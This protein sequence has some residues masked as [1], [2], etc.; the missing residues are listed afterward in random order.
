MA[1]AAKQ[2]DRIGSYEVL[3][4]RPGPHGTHLYRVKKVGTTNEQT[5]LEARAPG[6]DRVRV[7]EELKKLRRHVRT[8]HV[9]AIAEAFDAPD[10]NAVCLI[11]ERLGDKTLHDWMGTGPGSLEMDR[12]VPILIALFDALGGAHGAVDETRRLVPIV[13]GDLRPEAIAMV[14]SGR[15]LIVKVVGLGLEQIL[16]TVPPPAVAY[17]APEVQRGDRPTPASDVYSAG[18][19]AWQLLAGRHPFSNAEGVLPPDAT[20]AAR[21]KTGELPPLPEAIAAAVPPSLADLL[22]E[23][24]TLDPALRPTAQ[25]VRVR[26]THALNP[27]AWAKA[28]LARVRRPQTSRGWIGAVL[29]VLVLLGG[30]AISYGYLRTGRLE[31]PQLPDLAQLPWGIGDEPA[32]RPH[33]LHRPEPAAPRPP[34]VPDAA[35]APAPAPVNP[36]V[37]LVGGITRMVGVGDRRLIAAAL[38][39]RLPA[40]QTCYERR[41]EEV[42]TL[43]GEVAVQ[44]IVTPAGPF[45]SVDVGRNTTGDQ[46]L[47]LCVQ[48]QLSGVR[49]LPAPGTEAEAWATFSF[50]I[51]GD[52]DA[53]P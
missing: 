14:A 33:K 44:F 50:T 9:P 4:G 7:L 38:R 42:P 6:A 52:A 10:R 30:G 39:R 22:V 40:L 1:N 5:L 47:G 12:L 24:C 8:P 37:Q 49:V 51:G 2:G 28:R 29:V 53:G 16:P 48:R 45:A 35:V 15:S 34:V 20:L 13:H 23:L 36:R 32:P 21:M 25:S 43:T 18:I 26:L 41:L 31:L 3:G 27:L 17:A 11:T 46:S 19:I